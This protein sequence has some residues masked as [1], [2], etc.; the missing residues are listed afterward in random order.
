M[1][2]LAICVSALAIA[3]CGGDDDSDTAT[4]STATGEDGTAGTTTIGVTAPGA[5][6]IAP[7]ATLEAKVR[8]KGGGGASPATG[9]I[10]VAGDDKLTLKAEVE[11]SDKRP[12]VA[13]TISK[14]PAPSLRVTLGSPGADPVSTV[15]LK[16]NSGEIQVDKLTYTCKLAPETFCPVQTIES[17]ASY[18]FRMVPAEGRPINFDLGLE[19]G[20]GKTAKPAK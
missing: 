15:T 17:K 20:S 2:L 4:T 6:D 5:D 18:E 1:R 10:D 12:V 9:Q 13:I 19:P 16:S 14:G 11:N 8:V 3:G 7:E